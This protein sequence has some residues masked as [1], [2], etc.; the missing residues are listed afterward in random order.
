MFLSWKLTWDIFS[1]FQTLCRFFSQKVKIPSSPFWGLHF[2][3][4]ICWAFF[5]FNKNWDW[6]GHQ[7]SQIASIFGDASGGDR[8]RNFSSEPGF[9]DLCFWR[10]LKVGHKK[11]RYLRTSKMSF[12]AK[13]RSSSKV[14]LR[15]DKL[16]ISA[17]LFFNSFFQNCAFCENIFC[18]LISAKINEFLI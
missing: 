2:G 7:S 10:S 18:I 13:I 4:H 1:D 12:T 9:T 15:R 14:T 3:Q 8:R 11:F 6:Q 5:V 17:Q 16:T